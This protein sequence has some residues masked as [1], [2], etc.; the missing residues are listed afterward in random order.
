MV[1]KIG[2]TFQSDHVKKSGDVCNSSLDHVYYSSNLQ[3]KLEIKCLDNSS[4]DHLPVIC[5]FRSLTKM[6]PH[7]RKITKRC[8]KNFSEEKWTNSLDNREWSGLEEC[9]SVDEMVEIFTNNINESLDEVAPLKSFI[10]K[11]NYRFGISPETKNLMK[12]R[13]ETRAKIKQASSNE[14]ITLLSK[15]KKLRNLITCRIRKETIEHNEQRVKNANSDGEIW[16]VVSEVVIYSNFYS[17]TYLFLTL[18]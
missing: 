8:L 3:N 9:S 11:S 14:K 10:V 1:A 15:Y 2:S 16:K 18:Q 4:S 5:K 13:D 12:S 6:L 17:V 7:T